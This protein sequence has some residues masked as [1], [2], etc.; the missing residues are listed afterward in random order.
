MMSRTVFRIAGP[1]AGRRDALDRRFVDVDQ[2][3]VGLVVDLV[4]VRLERQAAGAEAMV[5]RD[6]LVGHRRVLDP[7]ADLARDEIR[8]QRVGLAI[9]QDVAKIGLPDAEAGLGVE[10]L[11]ERLAFLWCHLEGGAR[12]GAMDKAAGVSWQRAK[13]SG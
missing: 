7:L 1:D 12:I 8:D 3:D 6:Q 13:I 2:S 9:D 10:L 5:L 4:I 11:Q